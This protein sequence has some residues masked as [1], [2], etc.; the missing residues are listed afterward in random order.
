MKAAAH[1]LAHFGHILHAVAEQIHIALD[2]HHLHLLGT[3][4]H[5]LFR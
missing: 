5:N 2:V 3:V 1:K 4:A